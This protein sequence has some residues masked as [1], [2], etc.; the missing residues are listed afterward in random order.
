MAFERD[1]DF[2]Y[3]GQEGEVYFDTETYEVRW[4][5]DESSNP[6]RECLIGGSA[7][8]LWSHNERFKLVPAPSHE[9]WHNEFQ[10]W[11]EGQGKGEEYS[12]SIGL[13]LEGVGQGNKYDWQNHKYEVSVKWAKEWLDEQGINIPKDK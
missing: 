2:L 8:L 6:G 11:L 10:A 9:K 7:H 5:F 1:E 4:F 12:G 3:E 13:W